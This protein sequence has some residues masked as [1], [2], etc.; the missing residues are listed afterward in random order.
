MNSFIIIM[1]LFL[2]VFLGSLVG[3]FISQK[4]R[5]YA[6]VGFIIVL[7]IIIAIFIRRVFLP[8]PVL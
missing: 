2:T 7:I 8:F 3:L 1:G 5:K 4:T 6:L